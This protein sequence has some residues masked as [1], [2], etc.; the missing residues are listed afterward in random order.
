MGEDGRRR[1]EEVR[2]LRLGLDLGLT[3]IDTAEM[4]AAGGA[5]EVVGEAIAGR[6]DQVFLVSK[7]LPDNASRRGTVAACERSLARLG[8]DRLDLYLLH[9]PGRH[10]LSDTLAAFA[11]LRAAGKALAC[12]VSNFDLD[13]LQ[14][15]QA[16]A[17][18]G[19]AC[20]QVLYN[21][22]RRGIERRLLPHCQQSGIWLQAYSPLE[23]G[24]IALGGALAAVARRRGVTPAQ[25]ALA[26][27]CRAPGVTALAKATRPEHVRE[28]A[29]AASIELA[30]EDWAELDRAYPA[31]A[32]DVPLE[33]L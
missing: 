8:T 16:L 5:E 14:Q 24:R 27:A 12:G 13:L 21:L 6:R 1:A 3:L 9:W 32:R 28:N 2:A 30:A 10:R 7:V 20:N 23:Q 22:R 19:I 25:V 18:G 4:Y 33:T 29:A 26:F 31:P 15:A 17:P 11:E